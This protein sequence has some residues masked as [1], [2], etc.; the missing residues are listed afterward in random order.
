MNHDPIIDQ[1]RRECPEAP[2]GWTV[3]FLGVRTR[4]EYVAGIPGG[5]RP[6][7]SA[8]ENYFEWIDVMEAARA[9]RG[10]FAM[11]ELGAGYGRWCARAVAALRRVNP[12]PYELVA[13]EPEPTHFRWLRQHFEDN[14]I[15]P[16]RYRLVEA[17]VTAEGGPVSF[18]VG[19][20]DGWYGQAIAPPAPR[21]RHPLRRLRNAV[22]SLARA[23][24]SRSAT[25]V[26]R[27]PSVTLTELLAERGVVDLVDLDIQ[28]AEADVLESAATHLD[29]QVRR[30]HVGTHSEEIEKRL[31]ELFGGLGWTVR[32]DYGCL[33][34]RE[35]PIGDVEFVDGV[36]TWLNPRLT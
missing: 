7:P 15:D 22:R 1:L 30:V 2:P 5:E 18:W 21:E 27:V 33:G 19:N 10:R 32:N 23:L 31:R 35:T 14:G 36:Q 24:P 16:S 4:R 26:V 11:I 9:A 29:R 28:G 34:R 13:V 17:A 3:D 12:V 20:P 25:R 6:F 8:D